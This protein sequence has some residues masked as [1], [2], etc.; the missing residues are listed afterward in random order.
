MT[1][2]K[3]ELGQNFLVD[4]L[5]IEK[6]LNYINPKNH[7]SFLEIGPGKGAITE[8]LSRLSLSLDVVEIDKDLIPNLVKLNKL[9]NNLSVHQLDILKF[10]FN[11]LSRKKSKYRVVGNLPYNLSSQIILWSLKHL[12]HVKD[13][14]YMFQKEFGARLL[15]KPGNKSYG[16]ISILSQYMLKGIALLKIFPESFNPKPSVESMLIKFTP[17]KGR[18]IRSQEAVRLQKLTA[19]LFSKRRKKISSSCKNLLTINQLIDM[20][21]NP[22]DR[23]ESLRVSDFL[24]MTD[25]LIKKKTAMLMLRDFRNIWTKIS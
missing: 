9:H 24:R 19:M 20:K 17:I 10:N 22:D 2:A 5:V 6:I 1:K 18:N 4:S 12:D 15:A 11:D 14:H 16:R 8:D 25:Y 7:E 23:Q 21:I 3:K 13:F